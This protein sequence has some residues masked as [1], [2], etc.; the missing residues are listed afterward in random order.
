MSLGVA[1]LELVLLRDLGPNPTGPKGPFGRI[2]GRDFES[3][4]DP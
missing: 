3:A 4:S 2:L 1:E